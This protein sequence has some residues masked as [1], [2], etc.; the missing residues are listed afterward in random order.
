MPE[1]GLLFQGHSIASER[2]S[3]SRPPGKD[4]LVRAP[5]PQPHFHFPPPPPPSLGI[6]SH[7]FPLNLIL[8]KDTFRP[9]PTQNKVIAEY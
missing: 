2:L 1:A 3:L 8:K 9:P 4:A 6:P 5:P 7:L